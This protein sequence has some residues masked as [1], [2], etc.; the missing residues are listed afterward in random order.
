MKQVSCQNPL[1]WFTSVLLPRHGTH[2]AVAFIMQEEGASASH[3]RV[4][5]RA[6]IKLL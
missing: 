3:T 6:A 5:S 4:A 1:Q 2:Q